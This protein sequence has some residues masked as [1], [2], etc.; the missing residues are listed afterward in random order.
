M[1][2][3][4]L[5][6]TLKFDI[7]NIVTTMATLIIL[8]DDILKL[9]LY[10][11]SERNLFALL[12]LNK[13]FDLLGQDRE[14]W[15]N[16][17]KSTKGN[18]NFG[19]FARHLNLDTSSVNRLRNIYKS[20]Y[21]TGKLYTTGVNSLRILGCNDTGPIILNLPTLVPSKLNIIQISSGC[22]H[23][24]FLTD[25]GHIFTWGKNN[26][27]QLGLGESDK[28]DVPTPIDD[29]YNVT[30][31]ACGLYHTAFLTEGGQIFTFGFNKCGQLGLGNKTD[32]NI[33]TPISGF[34]NIIKVSCGHFHTA[35][36]T[37]S[38]DVYTFGTNHYGYLG[39][40]KGIKA[41]IPTRVPSLGNIV[42]VACG[43][44]NT[45]FITNYGEIYICGVDDWTQRILA[46]PSIIYIPTPIPN[47]GDKYEIRVTQVSCGISHIA[48]VTDQKTLYIFGSN[49]SGQLG[50]GTTPDITVP[51]KIPNFTNIIYVSCGYANTAFITDQGAIYVFGSGMNGVLGLGDDETRD[52]PTTVP[53]LGKNSPVVDIS[54]GEYN[55]Y[56]LTRNLPFD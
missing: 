21:T 16:K 38:G 10:T 17:I 49:M 8:P 12:S 6:L 26:H 53:E 30:Y 55:I 31:L 40:G 28:K 44:N 3:S 23:A 15:I 32:V 39:L 4:Y 27:G 47:F 34:T 22:E 9:L 48:F 5:K 1:N 11:T 25:E 42:D 46:E 33:P 56:F 14:F 43:R 37:N 41:L 2:F 50:L 13:K 7:K 52:I 29:F 45:V 36:I 35:F 19:A 18:K 20:I 24:A 51:T 54:C